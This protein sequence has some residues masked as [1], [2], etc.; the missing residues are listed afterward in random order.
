MSFN[1]WTERNWLIPNKG[2]IIIYWGDKS[3]CTWCTLPCWINGD[4]HHPK[5]LLSYFKPWFHKDNDWINF[6]VLG[7]EF[8]WIS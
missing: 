3:L 2:W 1:W 5:S 4:E 6:G 7:L 8:S